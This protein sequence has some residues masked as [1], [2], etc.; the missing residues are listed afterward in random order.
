MVRWRAGRGFGCTPER[1]FARTALVF[2]H[3][4]GYTGSTKTST[5]SKAMQITNLG[6]IIVRNNTGKKIGWG[7]AFGHRWVSITIHA[8]GVV[9]FDNA[10]LST[11]LWVMHPR[12]RKEL[13]SH[14]AS[15]LV[16]ERLHQQG[17]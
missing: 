4:L 3:V 10:E 13:R 1:C 6:Q 11:K 14:L 2:D 9:C 16:A 12:Q 5:G 17:V 8:N 15:M 7:C